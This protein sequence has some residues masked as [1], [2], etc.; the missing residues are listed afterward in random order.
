VTVEG[1]LRKNKLLHNSFV[2]N[3]YNATGRRNPYS[4]YFR[5]ENG[6]IRSY[7]YSIIGVPVFT[8]TWIFKLGNYVSD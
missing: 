7:S 2:L 1:D 4:V 5:S 8:A 6:R 3:L